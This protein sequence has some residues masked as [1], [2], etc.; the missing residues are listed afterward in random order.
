[1]RVSA[2]VSGGFLPAAARGAKTEGLMHVADVY[3]TLTELAGVNASDARAAAAGLPPVDSLSMWR[4]LA[5]PASPGAASPRTEIPLSTP[6]LRWGNAIT[7]PDGP[8]A[9]EWSYL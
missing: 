2:F 1:M 8:R 4:L 6:S 7:A 3:A 5:D 9:T